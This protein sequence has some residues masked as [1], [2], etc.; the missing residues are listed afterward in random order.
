MSKKKIC[1]NCRWW[2]EPETPNEDDFGVCNGIPHWTTRLSCDIAYVSDYE[3]Y[4]ASLQ[5]KSTFGCRMFKENNDV[6]PIS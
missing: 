6:P 3:G 2:S 4:D 1:K 5:T